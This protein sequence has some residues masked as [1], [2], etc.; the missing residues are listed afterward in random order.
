[1]SFRPLA[2]IR[3]LRTLAA[4]W[5]TA[6]PTSFRP[7][8]GIRGLRTFT[9]FEKFLEWAQVSVPLRG[10][11]VFGLGGCGR[12]PRPPHRGFRPLAGIRGLRTDG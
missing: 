2:G 8:A 9:M 5:N 4:C 3:G 10:L 1:M 7:L 6:A 11:E 12:I